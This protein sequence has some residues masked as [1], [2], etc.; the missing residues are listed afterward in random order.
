[1]Q[2]KLKVGIIGSGFIGR[3]LADLLMRSARYTV[4][5][6]LT[7]SSIAERSDFPQQERMTN[8][9]EELIAESDIVVECTGEVA[10]AGRAIEKVLAA[11]LKVVT[12]NTEF[13]I[14]LGSHFVDKGYISEAEGDQPGSIA[15]LYEEAVTMGFEPV[16]LGNIKGFMNL[17]PSEEDMRYWAKKSN[18]SL[19]MVTSFTDGT[20]V[21]MEQCFVAN[22]LGAGIAKQGLSALTNTNIAEGGAE[23]AAIAEKAGHPISDFLISS[24]GP[25]GVFVTAKHVE[26]QK[27]ALAYYKLGNGP[28]YTLIRDFHLPHMELVKTLDRAVADGPVLLD[29]SAAPTISVA[30]IAKHD[31]AAGHSVR[32]AIGSFDLRGECVEIAANREHVPIGLLENVVLKR[33]IKQGDIVTYD[34]VEFSDDYALSIWKSIVNKEPS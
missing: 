19:S 14:T 4:S 2:Q 29:N 6:V 30:A 9:I 15:A 24:T 18:L 1:M 33:P 11:G 27:A 25:A 21:Q 31:L 7:R 28:Y 5:K 32:K 16:V 13:H 12:M 3:N 34:D 26:S 22:G 20:K 17:D 8:A 23:L 10:Q